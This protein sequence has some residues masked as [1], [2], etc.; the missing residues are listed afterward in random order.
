MAVNVPATL[1]IVTE[2]SLLHAKMAADPINMALNDCNHLYGYFCPALVSFVPYVASGG[3]GRSSSYVVPVLPSVDGLDY[4]FH[5]RFLPTVNGTVTVEVE[6]NAGTDPSM[7]WGDIYAPTATGAMVA[8]DFFTHTHTATIAATTKMLRFTYSAAAGD[9][10][11]SHVL[12]FPAP[13]VVPT[14]LQDS[15][16]ACY[17]DALLVGVAG[18]PVTTEMVDRCRSNAVAV[19][20]DRW[21]VLASFVQLWQ[22]SPFADGELIV[23]ATTFQLLAKA[24]ASIP[25][26][27]SAAVKVLAIGSVDGGATGGLIKLL[28][29][30]LPTKPDPALLDATDLL[31]S[32]DYGIKG[33]GSLTSTVPF[34]L[35]AKA[36]PGRNT[37]LQCL[38]VLWRPG[39]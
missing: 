1:G 15:G 29:T 13:A 32:A 18:A 25:G 7:G 37:Y 24:M 33:N 3:G 14:G 17:D 21:Q 8:G 9:Y 20:R 36:K 10:L 12:A 6:E 31:V 22:S 39:D 34:E 19:L 23:S 4:E 2:Q 30:M 11:L 38:V 27:N 16:F 5:H 35:S 28:G 26:Q